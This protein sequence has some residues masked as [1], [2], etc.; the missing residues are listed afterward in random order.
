MRPIR[1]KTSA[2]EAVTGYS[3]FKLR[4]LLAEVFPDSA[5]GKKTGAH[6][7]FSR[8]DLLVVAVACEIEEKYGVER[9]KLAQ[10]AEAL[11]RELTGPRGANRDARLLIRFAPSTVT[12]LES[13]SPVA[14]GLVIQLGPL[15][16]KVDEYLG[17]SSAS[18]AQAQ[19]VL[20]LR[21]TIATGRRG[22]SRNR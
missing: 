21:P 14:E 16:E 18:G 6:R 7:T 10:A 3:R 19:A 13:G 9:K 8:Q 11:R 2:L 1:L 22:G 20:P 17:A 4:G 12:Y 15:F 5:R